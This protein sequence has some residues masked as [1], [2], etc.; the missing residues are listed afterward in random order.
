MPSFF[1]DLNG[2]FGIADAFD[3]GGGDDGGGGGGSS[4]KRQV[5]GTTGI[6]S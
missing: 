1:Q 2:A 5:L 4:S 3:G 6:H